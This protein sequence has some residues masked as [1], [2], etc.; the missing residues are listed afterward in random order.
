MDVNKQNQN[1]RFLTEEWGRWCEKELLRQNTC[2]LEMAKGLKQELVIMAQT[3]KDDTAS[4]TK[5][6]KEDTTSMTKLLKDDMSLLD[7]RVRTIS[8][9]VV[10]LKVKA[11]LWGLLGGAIPIALYLLASWLQAH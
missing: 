8:E 11:G 3:L 1:I 10:A 9:D 2:D 5:I 6:I 7:N 4:M